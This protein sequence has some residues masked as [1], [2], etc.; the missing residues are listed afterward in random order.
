M[1]IN[2]IFILQPSLRKKQLAVN[3]YNPFD[4]ELNDLLLNL[5]LRPDAK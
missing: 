5:L 1:E 3:E 4:H 2:G